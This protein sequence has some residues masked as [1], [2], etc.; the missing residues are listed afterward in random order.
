MDE[1][2]RKRPGRPRKVLAVPNAVAEGEDGASIDNGD[3]ETRRTGADAPEDDGGSCPW[4]VFVGRVQGLTYTRGCGIC[5]AY[6]PAPKSDTIAG[7]WTVLVRHGMLGWSD[8]H[9]TVN[10]I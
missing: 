2:P 4:D 8:S 3:G 6:H 7:N 9:G 1:Q 5:I 10:E